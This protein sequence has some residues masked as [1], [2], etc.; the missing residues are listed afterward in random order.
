[1]CA[2][3]GAVSGVLRSKA[4]SLI[5]KGSGVDDLAAAEEESYPDPPTHAVVSL[6]VKGKT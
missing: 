2:G 5:G 6:L 4:K 1:M 3:I